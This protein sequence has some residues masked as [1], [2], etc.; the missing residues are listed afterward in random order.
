MNE[1]AEKALKLSEEGGAYYLTEV[2]VS[3]RN[4]VVTNRKFDILKQYCWMMLVLRGLS[5]GRI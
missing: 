2:V 4:E 3:R 5:W 1:R